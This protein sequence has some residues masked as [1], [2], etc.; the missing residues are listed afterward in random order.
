MSD[1]TESMR[2]SHNPLNFFGV[3]K[4]L[5]NFYKENPD[6]FRPERNYCI[7]WISGRGK[8]FKFSRLCS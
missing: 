5:R 8:D 6:Y 7:F 2:G 3:K 4:Y 1:M